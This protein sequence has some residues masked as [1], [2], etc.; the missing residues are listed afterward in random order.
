MAEVVS[1]YTILITIYKF[2]SHF[3]FCRIILVC[4]SNSYVQY[5]GACHSY[6]Q[7]KR[8]LHDASKE[9]VQIG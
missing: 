5:V 8:Y 7:F 9:E 2:C 1:N 6:L 3:Y 4:Y